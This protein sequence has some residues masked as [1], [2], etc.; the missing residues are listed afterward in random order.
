MRALQYSLDEAISSLWRGRTS[1][2][3]STATIAVALF[4]LGAFLVLTTNLD[5]LGSEW[6]RSA[7]MSVYIDDDATPEARVAVEAML[8]PGPVVAAYQFVSKV[9]ALQH[10]K[11]TFADLAVA[12]DTLGGNPMPASYEVR[13]QTRAGAEEAVDDLARRL[14]Q[15]PGVVDVRYDRQWLDRLLAAVSVL[16]GVGLILGAFLALAAALTV[17]NVVR[18]AL[19]AR[20]DEIEIM[21]LVG[22]PAT[23]I[24]GPFVM[25]GVL[26]GG[27]GA[28]V[29]LA[30]LAAVFLVLRS[31]YLQPLAAAVNL[32]SVH[33]LSLE[34]SL[35]L[36][37]GGM[38]VG[39]FG[40][41]VA[42][43][44]KPEKTVTNP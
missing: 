2:V 8:T 40:G 18:L 11:Q 7:E 22:A 17:A 14:R 33:F 36:L 3:L 20:R 29:A 16:R 37:A 19:F 25:E 27:I 31:R 6:S 43:G 4:V 21:E 12:A 5:R 1:G 44:A 42:S 26:Q 38:L 28:T 41:F 13:L 39:C 32:S 30:G 15:A 9:E 35:F 10:F 34:L 23:Y 24:R